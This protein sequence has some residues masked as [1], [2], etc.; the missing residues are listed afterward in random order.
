MKKLIILLL[1]AFLVT[2][3]SAQ[4]SKRTSA[5]NY[6]KNGKLEKAKEFIDPCIDHPKTMNSAKTWYYR[7][8]IYLQIALD[9]NYKHLDPNALEVAWES[10]KKCDE[11]DSRGEYKDDVRNNMQIIAYN[12]FNS[13]VKFYNVK[14][15]EGAAASFMNTFKVSQEIGVTDTLALENVAFAYEL[16]EDYANAEATY[17]MLLEYG[18]ENPLIY[19]SLADLHFKMNDSVVAE[20]YIIAGRE[21]FPD[22][23]QLLIAE[24]N[25]NL[26][27]GDN[28]KAVYNLTQALETDPTNVTIWF[29]LGT[30]Y[31]STGNMEE[32]EAAYNKCIEIDPEYSNAYYNLGAMY[33]N[34]AADIMEK[35]NELPLDK[36]KEYDAEKAKS[37]ALLEKALP[38]LEKSDELKP[39]D[40]DTLITLKLIYTNMNKLDKLKEVNEKIKVLQQ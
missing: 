17:K 7:G 26:A 35:A 6:F 29:A 38:Y 39:D 36:V 10:Y 21:K 1:A 19:N 4:T 25:L 32:A 11:L 40:I 12:F 30:N 31:E 27:R 8:N 28:E 37:D 34:M 33:N 15:Y 23:Y 9:S 16:A 18:K 2:G 22:N 24:T 5:F 13:G 20:E 3:L 14:D